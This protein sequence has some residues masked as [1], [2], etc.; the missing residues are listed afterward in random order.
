[1]STHKKST[2]RRG[3]I[4]LTA[5]QKR[6][7]FLDEYVK[8]GNI[9]GA[10]EAAGIDRVYHYRW[11]NDPEYQQQFEQAFRCACDELER[12][13]HR[14]AVTGVP[15]P[16]FYQGKQCATIKEYSDTLLIFLMK[17][18]MPEKYRDNYKAEIDLKA[19]VQASYSI[20]LTTATDEQ[21]DRILKAA[22]GGS[23]GAGG[24]TG[25]GTP[26]AEQIGSHVPSNGDVP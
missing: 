25:E 16:Q 24:N 6:K 10:S 7:R 19:N 3:K 4:V 14:R 18:A 15:V 21:L 12:E 22:A 23:D 11:M 8:C 5:E 9:S 1:M 20:D 2:K 17:G 13:A 26:E